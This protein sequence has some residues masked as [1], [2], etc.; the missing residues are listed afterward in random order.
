MRRLSIIFVAIVALPCAVVLAGAGGSSED[1]KVRAIFDNASFV[2][3]GEDVKVAG[4][5]VGSI[6][7]IKLT[8]D[9]KAA[10]T[11]VITD[12]GYKDFRADAQC[13][14]RPQSLIGEQFVDCTP[15]G[16]RAAGE[17]PPPELP[18]VDGVHVLGPDHT[19]TSVGL[20]LIG[21]TARLP[22]RQRLSLILSELGIGLAGRGDDLNDVIRRSVPALQELNRV[23]KLLASQNK[24]L[25]R[26]AVDSDTI[27]GPLARERARV[28]GF[29]EHSATVAHATAEQRAAL[30]Q[31]L[32]KL[33][34][35][36]DELTPTMQ[37]L[38]SL[39]DQMTPVVSDLGDAAP[40]VD[41]LLKQMGPF[42]TAAIPA[43]ENL[44]DVA[45]PGI[46]AIKASI[47]IVKDLKEFSVQIKPVGAT[48]ADFVSSFQ[49]NDGIQRLMDY[50]YYQAL[51]VN[52]FD[53][54]GHYLRAG[55]LVNTCSTYAIDPT[56][57]CN[58]NFT[59]A[60]ASKSLKAQAAKSNG[61]DLILR[62]T[63]LVLSGMSPE[64]ALR[65]T[66]GKQAA[67]AERKQREQ[68]PPATTQTPVVG[69]EP[70]AEA[71]PQATAT[72]TQ[73]PTSRGTVNDLLDYLLG[74]DGP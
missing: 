50:L 12:P 66:G 72:P 45:E 40:D 1:Y 54:V 20:D 52:G 39:A 17:Q 41:E 26:L 19:S 30:E 5:K 55:L 46:P 42:S 35:F 59:Q 71:A 9:N 15:T 23:L 14:I 10:V 29:I 4:V 67:K 74:G 62:R 68:L 43:L 18:E 64:Q 33:P 6:G 31:T 36:L 53:S 56:P 27:M 57:G 25:K 13:K 11:L 38:S 3:K 69:A 47:P 49:S 65:A 44:G 70:V 58:A 22:A 48:L 73:T 28:S 51:A 8:R 60:S 37:R 7:D 24:T 61:L 32:Q 63:A 21:D 34:G 2:V 16:V